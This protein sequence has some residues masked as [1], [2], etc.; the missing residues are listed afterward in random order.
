MEHPSSQIANGTAPH[1]GA[2]LVQVW[3]PAVRLFHWT[4][5][6]LFAVTFFTE[7]LQS[8]HQPVGYAILGLVAFRVLWG[9]IGTEHARFADFVR[10]PQAAFSY[11]AGLLSGQAPRVLGHN[12]AGGLM[13]LM[14]LSLLAVT[15]I[16][17]W[18]L[19]FPEFEHSEWAEETH[20]ILAWTT[21]GFAA[22]HVLGVIASS[23]AHR[24]SLVFAMITGRKRALD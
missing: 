21:L 1:A 14:L 24:E 11:V 17:G 22:V 18:L 6:A 16:T 10:P 8:I 20:E 3:D 7:D 13:I 2:R 12:P 15:G 19:T 4:L 5:V 23:L 9:F